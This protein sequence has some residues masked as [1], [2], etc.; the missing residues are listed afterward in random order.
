M[1][2]YSRGSTFEQ[3]KMMRESRK[4]LFPENTGMLFEDGEKWQN[5]RS[6]VQQDLMRPKSAMYYLDEI[7]NVAQDFIK[8]IEEKRLSNDRN[9]IENFLPDIYRYT[10]ESICVIAIEQ[11]IGCLK[12]DSSTLDSEIAKMFESMK[13][14]LNSYPDFLSGIPTWKFL[15][16]RMNKSYRNAQ[17]HLDYILEFIKSRVD[18]EIEKIDKKH[19]DMNKEDENL[20][21]VSVLEKMIIRNG[22]S[23]TFPFVMAVD[24]IFAGIDT[25]GTALGC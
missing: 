8:L 19:N 13:A 21:D 14:F 7:Q 9:I 18:K 1:R 3:Y 10:L 11:R 6:K 2:I 24:M 5:I 23:S 17:D 4:D 12:N 16:P 15:P 22:K 20:R 25:T